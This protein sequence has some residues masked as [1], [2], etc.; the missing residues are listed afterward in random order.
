MGHLSIRSSI[1]GTLE[2]V[3]G[4][5]KGNISPCGSSVVGGL[6]SGD[7]ERLGE[8]GSEDRHHSPL[9]WGSVHRELWKRGIPLYGSSFRGTWRWAPLSG[10]QEGYERKAVGM[11]IHGG[12][13]GQPGVGTTTGDFEMWLKGSLGVD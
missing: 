4:L 1:E 5:R 9:S 13:V 8:E 12:S 6:F 3:G 7:L 10:V 11:D 2:I